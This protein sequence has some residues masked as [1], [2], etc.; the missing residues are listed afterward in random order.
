MKIEK[1]DQR[2]ETDPTSQESML[3]YLQG[4]KTEFQKHEMEKA[5]MNDQFVS[6]A[7]EGLLGKMNIPELNDVHKNIDTYIINRTKNKKRS[8]TKRLS[9]PMWI[10]LLSII[11]ILVSVAGYV[12]IVLLNK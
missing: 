9:F 12:L 2:N 7:I 11:V 4:N 6:D 5:L 10:V 1:R 3:N 8:P